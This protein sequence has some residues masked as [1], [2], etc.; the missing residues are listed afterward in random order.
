LLYQAFR[1]FKAIW[2]PQGKMNPG[3]KIDAYPIDANLRVGPDYNPPHPPTHFAYPKDEH[4]FAR[5]ALRTGRQIV[6]ANSRG[7]ASLASVVD[8]LGPRAVAGTVA[9][10]ADYEAPAMVK[11]GTTYYLLASHLSGWSANDNVYASATSLSGTW[12]SFE[13]NGGT[14]WMTFV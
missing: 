9:L 14:D 8:E 10:F 7:P 13:I 4:S 5:A 12:S 3:K 11:I 6:I 2:D 1:E